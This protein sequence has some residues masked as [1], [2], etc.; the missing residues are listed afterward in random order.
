MVVSSAR[1]CFWWIKASYRHTRNVH[2]AWGSWEYTHDIFAACTTEKF[3]YPSNSTGLRGFWKVT[4]Q[5]Q[6]HILWGTR[7]RRA[8]RS[9]FE[10]QYQIS[11][12]LASNVQHVGCWKIQSLC[13]S[14]ISMVV[15]SAR[16]HRVLVRKCSSTSAIPS[17]CRYK[18]PFRTIAWTN[19]VKQHVLSTMFALLMH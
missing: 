10:T 8:T 4:R 17:F 5:T 11:N 16:W 1:I 12:Y 2:N 14:V 3:F 7:V 13:H 19:V 18:Q 6:L 9:M 15:S